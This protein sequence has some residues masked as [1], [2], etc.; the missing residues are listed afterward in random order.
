MTLKEKKMLT[1]KEA[2]VAVKEYSQV[3]DRCLISSVFL[4]LSI[5]NFA[6]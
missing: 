2:L 6:L 4:P 3:M 5:V 1:Q